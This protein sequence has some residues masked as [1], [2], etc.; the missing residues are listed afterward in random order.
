MYRILG[1]AFKT[2][3]VSGFVSLTAIEYF[4]TF[5]E[6]KDIKKSFYFIWVIYYVW[7][8][9]SCYLIEGYQ[10]WCIIVLGI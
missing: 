2:L 4:K 7:Q 1:I 3:L 8:L 5:F 6:K 9:I 10:I